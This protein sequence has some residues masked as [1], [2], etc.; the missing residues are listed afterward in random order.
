MTA[1]CSLKYDREKQ[2]CLIYRNLKR[3]LV[4]RKKLKNNNNARP[5][6]VEHYQV[7]YYMHR[8]LLSL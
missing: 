1:I 4:Q 6:K 2:V 5:M 7:H 3:V 8:S